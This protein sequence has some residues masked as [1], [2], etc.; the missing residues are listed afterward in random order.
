MNND[1]ILSL[2]GLATKSGKLV[3]GEFMVEKVVKEHKARLVIIATDTSDGSKKN[4][5]DMCTFYHV[6][7]YEYGTKET[8]GHCI[9]KEIR[10]AVAVSDEG[11]A[12][13]LIQKLEDLTSNTEV[14][15]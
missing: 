1:K 6:P 4:Y 3:S 11:F 9:G 5:R 13:S 15:K 7:I 2:L 12:K 14:V 8:L 10:A